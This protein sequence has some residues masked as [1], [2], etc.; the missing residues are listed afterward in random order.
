M[1]RSL[2]LDKVHRKEGRLDVLLYGLANIATKKLEE[3]TNLPGLNQGLMPILEDEIRKNVPAK[4]VIPKK[5][6][7]LAKLLADRV[8]ETRS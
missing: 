7:E 3:K 5:Y 1:S 4:T 8:I 6:K 2:S